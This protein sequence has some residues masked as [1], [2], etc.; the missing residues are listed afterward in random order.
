MKRFEAVRLLVSDFD[1]VMTDNR[2]LVDENGRESVW[3]NRADGWGIAKLREAGVDV[4]VLSTETNAVVAARCRKLNI[5]C[6]S[7]SADKT[8]SLQT[9]VQRMNLSREHVAYLG[10]DVNDLGCLQWAGMPCAVAD[11]EPSVIKAAM[12]VTRRR[13]GDGAVRELCDAIIE[14]SVGGRDA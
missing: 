3:C 12:Y 9:L 10:N 8:T 4:V 1:G 6:I 2:V 13:G 14:D 11:S 7:G 5:K